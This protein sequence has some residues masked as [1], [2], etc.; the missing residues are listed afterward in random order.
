M[1]A[2]LTKKINPLLF[3]PSPREITRVYEALKNTG[4]D[5]LY[6]KYFPEEPAYNLGLDF[7]LAKEEYTHFVIC[8]DDLVVGKKH[9]D[10]LIADLV[11]ND[12]PILAGVCNVN[13]TDK[14][15]LLNITLNLPHPTRNNP[16]RNIIGW[17]YMAWVSADYDYGD[18]PIQSFPFSG[19]AA[20]FISRE[21]MKKIQ[22]ADDG[23]FNQE[24]DVY[25][26]SLDV[27]F[28]N[29]MALIK[30]PQRV[31][32]RVKMEHLREDEIVDAMIGDGEVRFYPANQ[33]K[34]HIIYEEPKG[35]KNKWRIV[36]NDKGIEKAALM[37]T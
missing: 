33:D 26:S 11:E 23:K 14:K 18:E 3:S 7:F 28:S 2:N 12:Y 8:P 16:K 6:S 19:F 29:A 15:D 5:R 35:N 34:Y 21:I 1:E 4:Y 31:D 13:K 9:I 10:A 20:Q 24:S 30:V 37:R 25:R 32:L 17:R 22:F 27:M 36:K